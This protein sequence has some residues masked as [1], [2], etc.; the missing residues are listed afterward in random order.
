[1]SRKHTRHQ[2]KQFKVK[3]ENKLLAD[4]LEICEYY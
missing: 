4:S 2:E 3:E 1:M